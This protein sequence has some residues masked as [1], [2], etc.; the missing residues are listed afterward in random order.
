MKK[1]KM[2]MIGWYDDDEEYEKDESLHKKLCALV[3][4]KNKA[5]RNTSLF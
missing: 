2:M 3:T 5:S 4:K 1:M